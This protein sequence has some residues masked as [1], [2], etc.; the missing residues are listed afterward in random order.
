M[1]VVRVVSDP[2]DVNIHV[3]KEDGRALVVD[4]SSGL[5]WPDLAPKLAAAVGDATVDALYLTHLHVDHVGG[6]AK[7]ARR[8]G[9]AEARMHESEA[10]VVEQGDAR[11]TG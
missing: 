11:L 7:V 10:F 9:L 1:K 2:F 8:F 6:A 3:V 5:D 4:A